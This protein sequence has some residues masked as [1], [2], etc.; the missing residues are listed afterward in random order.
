MR[1]VLLLVLCGVTHMVQA[2]LVSRKPAVLSY[3]IPQDA[4]GSAASLVF[5][6]P[7]YTKYL[8]FAHPKGQL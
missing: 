8:D 7:R 6:T 1:S 4:S 5:I 2:E 3:L